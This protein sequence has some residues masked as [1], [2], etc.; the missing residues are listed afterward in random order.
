MREQRGLVFLLTILAEDQ[1]Y[2]LAL[3]KALVAHE[4]IVDK[5]GFARIKKACK[6]INGN[7]SFWEH[8]VS[9]PSVDTEE[10][11]KVFTVN[12][13]ADDANATDDISRARADV[14]LLGNVV[15]VDPRAVLT[16]NDALG[17]KNRAVLAA[18]EG[19]KCLLNTRRL[20]G[21]RGLYAPI[22]EYLVGMVM[23]VV[24]AGAVGIVT[25]VIVMM[26]VMVALAMLVMIVMMMLVM[27]ALTMLAMIVMMLVMV[28]LAMLVMIV[29]MLLVMV[30]L[31]MII[32]MMVVMLSFLCQMRHV[33][34]KGIVFL[35]GIENDL[36]VK[37]I[38]VG[39]NDSSLSVMLAEKR[40]GGSQLF[41]IHALGAAEDDGACVFDLIVVELAEVFHVNAALGGV[42]YR[43]EAVET[44]VVAK[45]ALHRADDVGQLAHARRLNENTVGM[46]FVQHLAKRL[47]EVTDKA[48]ADTTAVHFGDL[49]ARL[50]EKAAVNADL[51]KLIFDKNGFFACVGFLEQLF[52]QC[53]FACAEKA[54]KYINFGHSNFLSANRIIPYLLYHFF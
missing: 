12:A 7:L 3:G 40:H 41:L 42:G 18:V 23:V 5:F 33:R 43:D 38:P 2:G 9:F 4:G 31:A 28:T 8:I 21:A 30:T 51:T 26:L 50:L 27:V 54:G 15:K 29:M 39:G 32:M 20:E 14:D 36:S 17:A 24:V 53:S 37:G 13:R 25:L 1:Q 48:T 6:Q 19:V 35:H 11:G 10:N 45:H 22:G 16:R 46:E 52:D 44:N 34:R 49:D 47:G